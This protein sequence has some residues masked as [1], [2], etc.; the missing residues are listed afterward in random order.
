MQQY[1]DKANDTIV[2][3]IITAVC[4]VFGLI[5]LFTEECKTRCLR[6]D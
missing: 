1:K 4:V 6:G 3:F 5:L 2:F